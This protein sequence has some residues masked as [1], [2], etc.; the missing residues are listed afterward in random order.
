MPD[1]SGEGPW[2]TVKKTRQRL[3]PGDRARDLLPWQ[4]ANEL[5]SCFLYWLPVRTFPIPANQRDWLREFVRRWAAIL[6]AQHS[7]RMELFLQY[8]IVHPD[9][10][11]TLLNNMMELVPVVGLGR[12]P[13]SGLPAYPTKQEVQS[14]SKSMFDSLKREEPLDPPD[15]KK[16][17]P[18]YSYWFV[19]KSAERQLDLF[20]G[21]GGMT[22]AFL[23]PD[24]KTVPPPLA[25]SEA[26]RKKLPVFQKMDVDKA[27]AQAASL[28]DSFLA[29]S[30]DLFGAG[31]E[32]EPQAKG[33][34][35]ILPI[36]DTAD[37]FSQ[38]AET[39]ENVFQLFDVYAKESPADH[40][41]VLAFKADLEEEFIQILKSMAEEKLV[42]P[43]A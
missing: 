28:A 31:L 43:E 11:N 6:K 42:Y 25:V 34:L 32:A 10:T 27:R 41:V 4:R 5:T 29:K 37:F 40:G 18:D 17:M 7:L 8:K 9:Y 3:T 2:A 20:F 13:G 26:Q 30:K 36:L 24:P 1:T 15:V 35:F 21:L 14:M 39:V 12:K 19:D 22:M 33:L 23:K 38:P 16:Y